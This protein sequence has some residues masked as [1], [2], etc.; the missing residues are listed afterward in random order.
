MFTYIHPCAPARCP[1]ETCPLSKRLSGG[2]AVLLVCVLTSVSAIVVE[3]KRLLKVKRG[4]VYVR[5]SMCPSKM[6][7]RD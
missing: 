5:R 4:N 1:P 7:P 3:S 6:S 2:R